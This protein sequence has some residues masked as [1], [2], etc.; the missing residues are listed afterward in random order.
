MR[1]KLLPGLTLFALL[2]L[3]LG[4]GSPAYQRGTYLL[5][6]G[7]FDDAVAQLEKAS[8]SEPR[9]VK[10]KSELVR[11]KLAAS[12]KHIESAKLALARQNYDAAAAD[13]QIALTFDPSNQYA[14]DM[15]EKVVAAAQERDRKERAAKTSIDDMKEA[16]A[17]DTGVPQIDPASNIPIVLKFTDTPLKTILDAISKA[18]GINFLYDE[19]ADGG[20]KVTVDFSKVNLSQAMD[21]LMTQTKHFYKVMDPHTLMIIPDNKQK[22]DEYTDQVIRTFYLS[23]A[24]AKEVFQLIRS[25]LQTRKMAMNQDL[26]SITI[27]DSPEVVAIAQ[28]II[29]ENDKSKGEVVVDVELLE[30]DTNKL[31]NLGID[32]S[33]HQFTIGPG[34]NVTTTT[35]SSTSGSGIGTGSGSVTNTGATT[36]TSIGSGGPIPL[37]EF[38]RTLSHNLFIYPVPNL[39]VNVLL[40]D[41]SSQV[42]A[43]PQLRV[44][45]GQKAS[46][47]IGDRIPIATANQYLGGSVGTGIT[48]SYT[49]ITSYTYQDVGVKIEIEPK[50]HH[51]KEVTIK[52]KSEVSAVTGEVPAVGLTPAQPIIGTREATTVIR[53][54]DGETSLLAGLIQQ[55]DKKSFSG[56]PG[57]SEIPILRR[58]F[59]NTQD[60]KT[61]TDVVLLLTPHIVRMPNITEDDL[62]PLWVGTADN[63]KLRGFQGGSFAP[64]PFKGAGKATAS[65][66]PSGKGSE[67]PAG[68]ENPAAKPAEDAKAAD[69]GVAATDQG[70]AAAA[71]E[72][73]AGGDVPSASA[74]RL[75]VSPSGMT[76]KVG[77]NAIVNLVLV[78]GQDLKGLHIELDYPTDVLKFQSADEG[79]FFKMGNAPSQFAAQESRPGLVMMDMGRGDGGGASGSG[80][81]G[82]LHFQALKAGVAKIN[83]GTAQGTTSAGAQLPMPPSFATVTVVEGAPAPPEGGPPKGGEGGGK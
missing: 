76:L 34:H 70:G 27:Q 13:L 35:S 45:E 28:K 75:L 20:K 48:G 47:H 73:A 61:S 69:Q 82:R 18:S 51:N 56:L 22:R 44:L 65:V 63:P 10:Y 25:I 55:Q 59:S 60:T 5:D 52:L 62:K 17:N 3:A 77:E 53:L 37:N 41:A 23:N 26:N 31:R 9:N 11:A 32:L 68:P 50:V 21:Y 79:A 78:G 67:P 39:I 16:V 2:A 83:F 33:T 12:Q 57:I 24:E 64:S 42:L 36:T 46:V 43:K 74:G 80:L 7:Q 29:E 1:S 72:P 6:R 14:S 66:Q 49:P 4:C 8:K 30:V 81:V 40:Q 15:M 71:T 19:K 38:G 54:E 58:L